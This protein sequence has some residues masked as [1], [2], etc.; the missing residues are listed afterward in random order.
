MRTSEFDLRKYVCAAVAALCICGGR[1][2]V[3]ADANTPWDPA[4]HLTAYW[5][6]VSLTSSIENPNKLVT[7]PGALEPLEYNKSL[8]ISG[9]VAILDSNCLIGLSMTQANVVALDENGLEIPVDSSSLR[10][11]WYRPIDMFPSIGPLSGPRPFHWSVSLP[12]DAQLG[13]PLLVSRLG[14][15]VY[16]LIAADFEAV[17]IS[18]QVTEDWV[19]IVPGMETLVEQADAQSEEYQYRIQVRYD[20]TKVSWDP[21]SILLREG[22]TLPERMHLETQILGAQ[23][24]PVGGTGSGGFSTSGSGSGSDGVMTWTIRGTGRCDDC[25]QA[26]S[27]RFRFAVSP[28]EQEVRFILEDIPVPTP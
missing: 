18:F 20:T 27:F 28:S 4:D 5:T 9:E 10:S 26:A 25:G 2:A 1:I 14:L 21:G 3:A 11:R 17:D 19:Q 23:G 7:D 22:E 12:E 13:Y 6:S 24:K 15:S 8:S 16:A